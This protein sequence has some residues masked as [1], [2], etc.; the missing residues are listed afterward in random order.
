MPVTPALPV[1]LPAN[2]LDGPS[3]QAT[4]D[5]VIRERAERQQRQTA[6]FFANLDNAI[7]ADRAANQY[8]GTNDK[9]GSVLM[10]GLAVAVFLVVMRRG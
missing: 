8:G 4:V 6:D 9:T 3:A 1:G 2:P 10:I 7:E 5:A